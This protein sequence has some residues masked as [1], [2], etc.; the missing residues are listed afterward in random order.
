MTTVLKL[1]RLI[2]IGISIC[3]G[4]VIF[5]SGGDMR[6]DERI[7]IAIL[8]DSDSSSYEWQHGEPGRGGEFARATH[9]WPWIWNELRSSEIDLGPYQ[10]SGTYP[11]IAGIL[12]SL[13]FST[14]APRKLDYKYNYS[15]SGIGCR[16]LSTEWPY[17]YRW[18]LSELNENPLAW[19]R[20]IVII[21]IGVNDIGQR[22]H[23]RQWAETGLDEYSK[24]LVNQCV[25]EI[26]SV[27]GELID[28]H[29]VRVAIVGIAHDYNWPDSF[30][31]WPERQQIAR[32]SAVLES[33]DTQLLSL[34]SRSPQLAFID[35]SSWFRSRF[36]DRQTE[37][38]RFEFSIST[39]VSIKNAIGN[40]P[41]NLILED[42]HSGT[43]ANA[44]W[45]SAMIESLND[46]FGLN[47]EPIRD[48]EILSLIN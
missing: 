22:A 27:A 33:F 32:I 6:I 30:S 31:E 38:L 20:G 48:E 29:D 19:K 2:V 18:L 36:G 3:V 39:N 16:S 5:R 41:E 23:L 17:Q 14:R 28:N 40:R 26:A 44:F 21:R 11:R 7:P 45:L 12:S 1:S 13:G 9:N 46:Q 35:D 34:A 43:V 37:D 42:G 15:L 25:D 8:G 10:R 47:L 4:L 24:G